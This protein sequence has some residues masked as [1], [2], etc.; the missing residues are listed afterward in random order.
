MAVGALEG[1]GVDSAA[2]GVSEVS[3]AVVCREAVD[4]AVVGNEDANGSWRKSLATL[5]HGC[6]RR[7]E[8]TWRA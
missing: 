4:P 7:R 3:A 5:L 8:R 1:V 2:V 6:K